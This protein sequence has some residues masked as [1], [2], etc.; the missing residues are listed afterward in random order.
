MK[1]PQTHQE[2]FEAWIDRS[3]RVNAEFYGSREAWELRRSA[4]QY[5]EANALVAPV[6]LE[7][8]GI[9]TQPDTDDV[10]DYGLTAKDLEGV[11]CYST[12]EI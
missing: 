2:L 3:R 12:G 7:T 4:R 5:A 10:R 8:Y 9:W 6:D 1:V 11:A